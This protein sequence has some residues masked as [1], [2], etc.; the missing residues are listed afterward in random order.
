MNGVSINT[1]KQVNSV[2]NPSIVNTGKNY[3]KKNKINMKCRYYKKEDFVQ[4]SK[5]I[6]KEVKLK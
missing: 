4:L 1:K 3:E 2:S 5:G 6:R